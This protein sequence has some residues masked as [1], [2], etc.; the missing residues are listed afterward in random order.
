[1]NE[2][3]TGAQ[4]LT[5]VTPVVLS[6]REGWPVP[7]EMIDV[8]PEEYFFWEPGMAWAEADIRAAAD[9]LRAVRSGIGVVERTVAARSR[10]ASEASLE[11]LGANY[12]RALI[13]PDDWPCT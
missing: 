12:V 11:A 1:V 13:D 3:V 8:L 10:I 4:T 9:Q 5:W 6:A 2:P 7:Y